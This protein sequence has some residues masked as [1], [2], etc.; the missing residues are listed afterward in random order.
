MSKVWQGLVPGLFIGFGIVGAT[1]IAKRAADSDL[2]VLAAPIVLAVSIL[3]ADALA[4]AERGRRRRPSAG[5]WI[6]AATC[7][8]DCLI[9]GR[10]RV[11]EAMPT[12]GVMSWL[13]LLLPNSRPQR[14]SP[15]RS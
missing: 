13:V 1:F 9:V 12:L 15:R 5:A 4:A 10:P 2:F 3:A 8:I 7:L 6:L 11:A 14:C